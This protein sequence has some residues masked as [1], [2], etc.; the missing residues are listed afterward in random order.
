MKVAIVHYWLS[1]MRGGE[2]VLEQFSELFPNADI[3]THVLSPEKISDKLLRHKIST[4]FIQKLPLAGRHYSKYLGFMPMALERFDLEGYDLVI[5]SES[6]PAKGIIPP[7]NAPH[8]C[9]CHSPMRYLWD[10][11]G[12]YRQTLGPFGRTVFDVTAHRMRM[13]DVTSAAR[14]DHFMANSSFV[15][16]RIQKYYRR[17]A[18]VVHPP[19]ALDRFVPATGPGEYYVFVSELVAYK[20]ADIA[21]RAFASLDRKLLIVGDG[22]ERGR[23]EAQATPNVEFLGRVSNQELSDIYRGA[24]ALVFPGL[25]DF[26]IVP[27]EAMA[28][29]RPVIAFGQGGARDTVVPG[30]TGM[31]F[32]T[33]T[34]EALTEAVRRFE[35]E[36]EETLDIS[37][38]V[39]HA[40]K[41]SPERFRHAFLT[42]LKRCEPELMGHYDI[43]VLKTG[44]VVGQP[45]T[46]TNIL[47]PPKSARA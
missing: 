5:S 42:H 34:A 13:W 37:R 4:S 25:E 45:E 32:E 1:G 35:T 47:Q 3:F 30:V 28:S 40:Q 38:I 21:V 23:L 6:G 33:Q 26:G 9:Y 41:F 24:R 14:V 8:V 19:V 43:P 16:S 17:S 7:A 2:F 22:P 31:F 39:A 10:R 12:E 20:R 27:L 44:T 46:A 18:E 29:G 11:Y 15:Q 36:V